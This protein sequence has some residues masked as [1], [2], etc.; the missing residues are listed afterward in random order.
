MT[1]RGE[2]SLKQLREFRNKP[3]RDVSIGGALAEVARDAKK[4]QRAVGGIGSAWEEI[5][6]ARLA[7]RCRVVGISRGILTF[8]VADAAAR[9]ELDRFLRGGGEA[10]LSRRAGVG[11]KRVKIVV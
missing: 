3:E 2:P 9:F 1:S 6:P 10:A 5:A 7:G 11:I 4:L 8:R